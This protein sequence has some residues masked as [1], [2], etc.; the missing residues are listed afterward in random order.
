MHSNMYSNYEPNLL[1]ALMDV[2]SH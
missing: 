2:V 1:P